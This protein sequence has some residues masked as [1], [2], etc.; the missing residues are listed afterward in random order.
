MALIVAS[1]TEAASNAIDPVKH[2]ASAYPLFECNL[3]FQEKLSLIESLLNEAKIDEA[4]EVM[5]PMLPLLSLRGTSALQ[6][7]QKL[8]ELIYEIGLRYRRQKKCP[9]QLSGCKFLL[10][11]IMHVVIDHLV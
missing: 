9:K 6:H 5:E 7:L 3:F 4:A 2:E 1:T 10:I 8:V 11:N